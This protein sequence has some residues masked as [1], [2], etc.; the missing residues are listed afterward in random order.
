MVRAVTDGTASATVS[1][2]LPVMAV[3][4]AVMMAV[5]GPAALALPPAPTST[6]PGLLDVQVAIAV[7]ERVVPSL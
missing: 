6:A 7:R 3:N 2:K 1:F 5:P 4:E